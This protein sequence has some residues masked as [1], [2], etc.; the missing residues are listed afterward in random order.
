V[1]CSCGNM[2]AFTHCHHR[3][4]SHST[5]LQVCS[6]SL[7]SGLH[8]AHEIRVLLFI[9]V[10]HLC[11]HHVCE[12]YNMNG[13]D[14]TTWLCCMYGGVH[15]ALV[16]IFL[17]PPYAS[18]T[19][20]HTSH[21]HLIYHDVPRC[22]KNTDTPDTLTVTTH[23]LALQNSLRQTDRQTQNNQTTHFLFHSFVPLKCL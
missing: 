11:H 21:I 7:R 22:K 13:S 4:H 23:M 10:V 6:Y 5:R 18:P 9:C 15:L 20:A 17:P 2:E 3:T 14:F 8:Q 19:L 12:Y 1:A 16:S